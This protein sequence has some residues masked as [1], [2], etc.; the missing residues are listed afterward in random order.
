MPDEKVKITEVQ[1]SATVDADAH[2]LITQPNGDAIETLYR[3]P[4]ADVRGAKVKVGTITLS[5]T[6]WAGSSSP[7]SQIVTVTGASVTVNTKVDLQ[8][9]NETLTYLETIGVFSLY[10]QNDGGVLTAYAE[11]AKPTRVL[12]IQVTLT[13]V[14]P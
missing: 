1:A 13:E 10:I 4:L 12:T 8:P 7:Y 11:G 2:V 3:A 6:L 5:P 14:Q 9:D